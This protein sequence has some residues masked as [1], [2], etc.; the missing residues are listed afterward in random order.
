[1]EAA[2]EQNNHRKESVANWKLETLVVM[3]TT[4]F[5]K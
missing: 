3:E 2:D 1:M 5:L 4:P